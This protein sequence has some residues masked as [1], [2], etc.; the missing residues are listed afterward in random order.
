ML[1]P[2]RVTDGRAVSVVGTREKWL[3]LHPQ[4]GL[5]Q[6]TFVGELT[7][8]KSQHPSL[9]LFENHKNW[10]I[11]FGDCFSRLH[12][13]PI[14]LS[15]PHPWLMRKRWEQGRAVRDKECCSARL[16]DSLCEWA[17]VCEGCC[18]LSS[19]IWQ[20]VLELVWFKVHWSWYSSKF[21]LSS[22][23]FK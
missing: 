16:T 14:I 21:Q 20:V 23:K 10:S 8:I 3:R 4:I 18:R 1:R 19:K 15:H 11:L 13:N 22:S 2:H 12:F 7:H 5:N 6:F 9:F 17:S